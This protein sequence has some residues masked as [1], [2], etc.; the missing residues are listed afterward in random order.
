MTPEETRRRRLARLARWI[1]ADRAKG[2]DSSLRAIVGKCMLTWGCRR[3][4]VREYLEVLEFAGMIEVVEAEDRISW[5]GG[6]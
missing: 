2:E 1:G 3:E 5:L 6:K 4:R